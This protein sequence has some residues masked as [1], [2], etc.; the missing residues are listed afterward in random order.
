MRYNYEN[1]QRDA[2]YSLIY[3]SNSALHVLGDVF[4]HRQEHLTVFTES[5]SVHP[6][7]CRLM[8][9]MCFHLIRDT[10]RQLLG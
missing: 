3:Y 2:L 4:A 1:N 7:C 6:S 9:R 8:S 10:S 5:G